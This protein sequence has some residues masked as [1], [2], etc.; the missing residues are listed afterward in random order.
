[1]CN[2]WMSR[3][4][5]ERAGRLEE[6]IMLQAELLELKANPA[7][8]AEGSVVEAK[9]GARSRLSGNGSDSARNAADRGYFCGRG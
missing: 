6:A 2:V 3:P 9:G 8:P 7:R 5:P 4:I 1:M